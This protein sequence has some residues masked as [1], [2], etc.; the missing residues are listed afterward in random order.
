[1]DNLNVRIA[2]SYLSV[3]MEE[4][5]LV[6]HISD[7]LGDEG[8]L[9]RPRRVR[10]FLK[11]ALQ[12]NWSHR[13]PICRSSDS[14]CSN[15]Y[16]PNPYLAIKWLDKNTDWGIQK[17]GSLAEALGVS[18][19]VVNKCRDGNYVYVVYGGKLEVVKPG[20]LVSDIY[21][22]FKQSLGL[23]ETWAAH[24][25]DEDVYEDYRTHSGDVICLCEDLI[26]KC[27]DLIIKQASKP[28]KPPSPYAFQFE[29]Q[30]E[31]WSLR[32]PDDKSCEFDD[33]IGLRMY[34]KL[35]RYKRVTMTGLN[36]Y[37][38]DETK[39]GTPAKREHVFTFDDKN[40]FR[41]LL[42]DLDDKIAAARE[43]GMIDAIDELETKRDQLEKQLGKDLNIRGKPRQLGPPDMEQKARH[44]AERAMKYALDILHDKMPK[45]E[46]YLKATCNRRKREYEWCYR[47]ME[48]VDWDL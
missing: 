44:A 38:A 7:E 6:E 37:E 26:I 23:P 27:E 20:L 31:R 8:V 9:W 2:R 35:L 14:Q 40:K 33:Y 34:H 39:L 47:P 30:K 15:L 13:L 21:T 3:A 19:E 22:Q 5:Q 11:V 4:R 42:D 45:L 17:A 10:E 12:N 29:E 16:Y 48:E 25:D 36:L 1:M 41:R 24:I 43:S 32:F 18:E 28:T 46:E